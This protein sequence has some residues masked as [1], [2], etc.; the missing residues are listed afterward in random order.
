MLHNVHSSVHPSED[1]HHISVDLNM[2]EPRQ[3]TYFEALARLFEPKCCV[4]EV[5][6]PP[7]RRVCLLLG[8]ALDLL[9]RKPPLSG[10]QEA[11]ATELRERVSEPQG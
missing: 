7:S 4:V 5:L 3:A 10:E 8:G 1:A 2:E 11:R 9:D 6:D